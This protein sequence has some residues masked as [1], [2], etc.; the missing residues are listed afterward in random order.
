LYYFFMFLTIRPHAVL[1]KRM[2]EEFNSSLK[3]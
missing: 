1:S 3:V 2:K